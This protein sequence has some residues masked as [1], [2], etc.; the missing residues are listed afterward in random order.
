MRRI[1]LILAAAMA[2]TCAIANPIDIQRAKTIAQDYAIAGQ[3]VTLHTSAKSRRAN[4][5][6]AP[7]Y[8]FSRG[9]DQGYVIVAGDD[10]IPTIIGFTDHGDFDESKEAPQL[11]GLLNHYAEMVEKMQAEGRNTPYHDSSA[12]RA[13]APGIARSRENVPTLLTTHWKQDSPYNDMVPLLKDGNRAAAGCVAIAGGQVFYYWRREMPSKLPATTPTYG[14]GDVPVT[15]D[16]VIQKGTPLKWNLMCNSY[17]DQ[18]QEYRQ[19]VA[20][21]TAAIGMQTWMSYGAASGAYIWDLPFALYGLNSQRADKASGHTDA[22]WSAL[23]YTDLLKGHPIIYSGYDTNV[24]GHAIVIDGYRA[25]GDLFHFNY[26]WGGQSDGYYTV[27]E[28]GDNNIYYS[29]TPTVMY[30]IYPLHQHMEATVQLPGKIYAN[31]SNEIGVRVTNL[32][33]TPASGIY[34]FANTTGK[35]P[36]SLTSAC[37]SDTESA[38]DTDETIDL[39]LTAMPT[40]TT[41]WYFYVTDGELKVLDTKMVIPQPSNANLRLKN[42]SIQGSSDKERHGETDFTVVY[43]TRASAI[44]QL[45]N[46]GHTGYCGEMTITIEKSEDEGATW[47]KVGEKTGDIDIKAH[48]TSTANILITNSTSTP[49]KSDQLY[50]IK[51]NAPLSSEGDSLHLDD[52]EDLFCYF[53]LKK[54]DLKVESFEDGILTLIGH[55]DPTR[56]NSS[57]V[58]LKDA[59]ASVTVYDLRKVS[60]VGSIEPLGINPNALYYVADDSFGSGVNVVKD[61]HCEHLSLTQGHDFAPLDAFHISTST[62]TLTGKP[63][64]WSVIT[65]PVTVTVPDGIIARSIDGHTSTG[66]TNKTT[67]VTVMEAGHTYLIMTT[68]NKRQQLA[69]ED[70]E[71]PASPVANTD[72]AFIGTYT[73]IMLPDGAMMLN[74]NENQSFNYSYEQSVIGAL[75]GYFKA[76]DINRLFF[77]NSNTTL[78]PAYLVLAQS[79][80]SAR[81]TLDRHRD[82][83]SEEAYQSFL[84]AIEAAEHEFTHRSGSQLTTSS[85][86]KNCAAELDALGIDYTRQIVDVG[87]AEVDFSS[88]ITNPSF[89]VKS[90]VGWTLTQPL[91][92]AV[93]SNT[94]A[95]VCS[96]SSLTYF[97]V[98]ADGGYLLN[99]TY[100]YTNNDGQKGTMGVGISQVVSGLLPGYYRLSAMVTSDEGNTI[101]VFAGDSTTTVTAHEF[102]KHYLQEAVVDQVA[103]EA[104]EGE[105][106]G[107]LTIGIRPG[108]W[109]KADHFRLTYVGSPGSNH[110][111]DGILTIPATTPPTVRGIYTLQGQRIERA[112]TPGIYIIDGKKVIIRK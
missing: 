41:P 66:I 73:S 5:L 25:N 93:S 11:L 75:S 45:Q 108:Q 21:F 22:T 29:S 40:S 63:C 53:I 2:T 30:D 84:T 101:T 8:I 79:I 82:I 86:I 56:F 4:S 27:Y 32:S 17:S 80:R 10:C 90:T 12:S 109:Y 39:T 42:M 103:V 58:A 95:K 102:G 106:T 47:Q 68:D 62:L 16:Y 19:A 60:S 6:S 50:R 13:N 65:T 100:N 104:S 57:A 74:D 77:A 55:W 9:E 81:K 59:Y 37:A 85:K 83:V 23:I 64:K 1:I 98:G 72:S 38:I 87:Y 26:G 91:N 107:T 70:C 46:T 49:I 105:E 15:E 61:G 69:G 31:V 110:Q 48:D 36:S 89:E 78:D 34:L 94:A 96:N 28:S 99:N 44:A 67:D 54:A 18:P 92:T 112:N 7:Y 97:S 43:N 14:H 88:Y 35:K 71:V 33:T 24:E 111:T 51:A 52:N 76:D 20:T 3:G